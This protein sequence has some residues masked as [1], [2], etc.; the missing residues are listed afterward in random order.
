MKKAILVFLLLFSPFVFSDYLVGRGVH[1]IT[2][3]AA[4]VGMLGYFSL[5]QSTQGIHTRLHSRAFAIADSRS[6]NQ[7]L[8]MVSADLAMITQSIKQEV[9]KRLSAKYGEALGHHNVLLTPTHTH[10][11]PG[12]LS[13]YTL[14]NITSLGFIEQNFEV[15]V[16][17]IIKSIDQAI[18]DMQPGEVR[19]NTGDLYESQVNRSQE[20][21]LN[22]PAVEREKYNDNVD[23]QM[24]LLKFTREGKDIGS[25]N[26]FPVHAVSMS[27][28][29]RLIS[30]DNKGHASYI[31]EKTMGRTYP[32]REG[33]VAAFAQAHAGDVSPNLNLDGTGP[34]DNE[35]ESTRIIGERQADLA[36]KL[37]QDASEQLSGT[38]SYR[39]TFVDFSEY[40]IEEEKTTCPAAL[41]YSVAAGTEDGPGPDFFLEGENSANP[42]INFATSIVAQAPQWLRDCHEEKEILIATGMVDPVPWTPDVVPLQL[43]KIGQLAIIG[44]PAEVTTMA[45]RRLM[46]TVKQ[47]FEGSAEYVVVSGLANTYSGY[48]ST[49]EEYEMQHYEGGHTIFGP[50]TLAAYEK[51]FSQLAVAIRENKIVDAGPTPR[52]LSNDQQTYQPGVVFDNT[53]LGRWYG[54]VYLQPENS[55]QPGEKV[56]VSFWTGHPKND[57]KTQSSYLEVQR[58]QGDQWVVV[59][60]DNDWETR[61]TW[62]RI[63][64]AMSRAEIDWN[65]PADIAPGTYRILH[66]GAYRSGITGGIYQ[67]D[68]VTNTFKV[69][70]QN[71]SSR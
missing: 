67:F 28:A 21:Y 1:D 23:H 27:N 51:N 55:Y 71:R 39:H 7:R 69:T 50:N 60:N 22:N 57:L 40:K 16:E 47:A 49:R 63:R 65:I 32:N 70:S 29:N 34:G 9:V 33:F 62:R 61:Y 42:F 45:G 2:G 36:Q 10:A 64:V 56:S 18:A 15:V 30:S 19:I 5:E 11:A 3:P 8:V 35:F 31:V 12:G 48:V 25:W 53:P 38:I 68:G 6:P 54:D 46:Q 20:A 24:T 66:R 43:V 17:G 26:W 4:E 41:G 44:I 14:T 59:A 52:D 13:H 58:Q 37:Y